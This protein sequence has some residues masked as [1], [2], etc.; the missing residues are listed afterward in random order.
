MESHAAH[1]TNASETSQA[2]KDVAVGAAI[3]GAV[4]ILAPH[5]LPAVGIGTTN[6]A[7]D[8]MFFLHEAEGSGW[9]S[10]INSL[11]KGVPLIGGKLAEGG[12]FNSAATALV[13]VGGVMLGKFIERK[14]DGKAGIKWGKMIK[15]A[16]IATSALIA[17]PTVLTALGSGLIFIASLAG[18]AA[19]TSS[20][21]GAVDS[22]LGSI[23]ASA[24]NFTGLSGVAATIPHFLTCGVSL[25]PAA[26][27]F[28][29]DREDEHKKHLQQPANDYT[30]QVRMEKSGGIATIAHKDGTPLNEAE[31]AVVHTRKLHM[32]VV[33][34]SLQ[35]YHHIHP[36]PTG[37]PGEFAFAFTPK[38]QNGYRAWAEFTPAKTMQLERSFSLMP[39]AGIRPTMPAKPHT[40]A[41]AGGLTAQW[42]TDEPLRNQTDSIISIELMDGAGKPVTNLEP[43]MGAYAHLVG[44]SADRKEMVHCHPLGEEPKK[45]TARGGPALRFHITPTFDGPV[46]F[47][48][49][50][51]QAGKDVFIPI[52][53]RILPAEKAAEKITQLPA[54]QGLAY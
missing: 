16:A 11:L 22:T 4:I 40:Q 46:Q 38:T 36:V 52:A 50:V 29:M 20:I 34:D 54:Q 15:Y 31:L 10:S 47:Y 49:Q 6:A 24:M 53:Q 39:Y 30:M 3:A 27:A 13:G 37:V 28:M 43:V 41:G 35:D 2:L 1:H 26:L 45:D 12:L 5:I 32:F 21:I 51:K 18:D 8:S 23:G 48:L 9:A 33:D 25:L 42:S 19:Y 44:F 14:E 17:L 7:A